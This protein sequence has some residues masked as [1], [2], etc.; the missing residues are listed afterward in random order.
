MQTMTKNI[1]KRAC[2]AITVIVGVI[3]VSGCNPTNELNK[4]SIVVYEDTPISTLQNLK[5]FQ[6]NTSKMVSAG[7]PTQ[8]H[9]EALKTMGV[10]TVIDLLPGDRSSEMEL[11]D[12]LEMPYHN[13]SVDWSNPTV[14]NFEQYVILMDKSL[15]NE[16]ITLTHCKLNWRGAVFT[17]LY[18][19]TQLNEPEELA[20]KDLDAIWR[21]NGVWQAF[22][23]QIKAKYK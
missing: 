19:T 15:S 12:K 21:A 8:Q 14:E 23:D 20:K 17:Y 2:Y 9:F 10:T 3:T 6:V 22:I 1:I 5:N 7:M 18:R 11:M 16:G 4:S 13:I